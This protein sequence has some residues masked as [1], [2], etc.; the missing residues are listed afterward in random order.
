M[1]VKKG[2]N[3]EEKQYVSLT[4][5]ARQKNFENPSCVIQS[6]LR[7]RNTIDV[8]YLWE[9]ENNPNFKKDN[10]ENIINKLSNPSFTLT[11][12]IW[13]EETG[14][15]GIVSKQGNGGRYLCP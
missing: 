4:H 1:D 9:T 10:Y 8:L 6:W 13:K 3:V 11:A 7:D 15:I 14:A 12:K 2:S 5:I